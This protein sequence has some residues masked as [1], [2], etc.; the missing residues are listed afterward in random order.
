M[1]R[2][3]PRRLLSRPQILSTHATRLP[4]QGEG[5]E[6]RPQLGGGTQ[7]VHLDEYSIDDFW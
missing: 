7:N 2:G 4:R 6:V 1:H 5:H 3:L